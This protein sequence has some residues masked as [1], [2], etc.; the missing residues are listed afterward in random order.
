MIDTLTNREFEW[1]WHLSEIYPVSG[2]DMIKIY[3]DTK[4]NILKNNKRARSK[5]IT[6]QCM[7]IIIS[8]LQRIPTRKVIN[9]EYDHSL[10]WK[11][12]KKKNRIDDDIFVKCPVCHD[13]YLV[14]DMSLHHLIPK[15]LGEHLWYVTWNLIL[16]CKD[17]HKHIHPYMEK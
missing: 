16:V 13:I 7:N 12:F 17:C 2:E 6:E 15:D 1:C 5:K 9:N 14:K 3:I 10:A 8:D 4:N 11:I